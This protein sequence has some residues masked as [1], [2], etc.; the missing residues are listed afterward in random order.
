MQ[1]FIAAL[2]TSRA[3]DKDCIIFHLSRNSV[4]T[5]KVKR[6]MFAM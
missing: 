1:D 5:C 4:S 2:A 3:Q 6:C